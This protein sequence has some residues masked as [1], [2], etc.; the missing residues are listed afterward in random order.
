LT[1]VVVWSTCCWT[2]FVTCWVVFWTVSVV[3]FTPWVTFCVTFSVCWRT[4]PAGPESPGT[5]A[6]G[7]PAAVVGVTALPSGARAIGSA[8]P[9]RLRALRSAWASA[10]RVRASALR[11]ALMATVPTATFGADFCAA[12]SFRRT[13]S[14]SL[15]AFSPGQEPNATKALTSTSIATAAPS[16][17]DAVPALAMYALV[18]RI[19]L[20]FES[21]RLADS[22][23]P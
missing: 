5:A 23:S 2:W 14:I 20:R 21:A 11:L 3:F 1:C 17:T 9:P 4:V 12:T 16:I 7:V 6:T 19:P 8:A 15:P 13:W 10:T 22:F 18:V